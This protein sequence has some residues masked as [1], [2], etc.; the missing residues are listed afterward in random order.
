MRTVLAILLFI[1]AFWRAALDW[2]ATIGAGYAYRPTTIGDL[3]G[4]RWPEATFGF[5]AALRNSG[6][7]WA[8]D[9]VG[10][11]ALSLPFAPV[12]AMLGTMLWIARRRQ[13]RARW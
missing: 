2:R 12:L 9:P 13:Q 10:A 6:I 11:F 3:A 8:W 5:V 7:G 4:E 1:L